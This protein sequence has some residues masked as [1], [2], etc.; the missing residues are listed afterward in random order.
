MVNQVN[1]EKL[2]A[3]I[4]FFASHP[5]VQDLGK[6]KLWKLIYY[7][8][9]EMARETGGMSITGS[10]YI[11]YE[12]GPVPSRGDKQLKGLVQDG[13]LEATPRDHHGHVLLEVLPGRNP[14]PPTGLSEAEL[15]MLGRV[16][17]RLGRVSAKELSNRSH[18]EPAWLLADDM[19]KLDADLMLYGAEED[20]EEL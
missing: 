12:H 20:P 15:E 4:S 3:V 8:D 13:A 11:K 17:E 14:Q 6:T 5:S 9:A 10:E 7:A 1:K 2:D 19:Q 18:Q 16:A